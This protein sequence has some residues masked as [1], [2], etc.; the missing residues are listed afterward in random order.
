MIFLPE[1]RSGTSKQKKSTDEQ[2]QE[3]AQKEEIKKE[4][5]DRISVL[6]VSYNNL[7]VEQEFQKM[8]P[9]A[10]ESYRMAQQ[11]ALKYL[12]PEDGIFKNLNETYMKAK[13]E[14]EQRMSRAKEK[15]VRQKV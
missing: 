1:K 5:K 4:F 11:F 10:L 2:E 3:N 15:Q 12:G 8:F 13:N 7:G 6:S 14:I 9:E